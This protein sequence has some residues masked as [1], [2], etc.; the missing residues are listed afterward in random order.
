MSLVGHH[1]PASKVKQELDYCTNTL[2]FKCS[3]GINQVSKYQ[4]LNKMCG[5]FVI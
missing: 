3:L 4:G 1:T 2:D 5:K